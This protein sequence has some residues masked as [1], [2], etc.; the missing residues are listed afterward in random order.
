MP[1]NLGVITMDF[2]GFTGYMTQK[3]EA[4]G[5]EM[6]VA[7]IIRNCAGAKAILRYSVF[8]NIFVFIGF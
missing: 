1:D 2:V 4:I 3:M 8:C 5:L 7:K 6:H